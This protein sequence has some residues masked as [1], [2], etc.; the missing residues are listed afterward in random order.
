MIQADIFNDL[1]APELADDL[2]RLNPQWA[3]RPGPE[4][5]AF[6]RHLFPRIY[7]SL[8]AGLTPATVLR[9]LQVAAPAAEPEQSARSTRPARHGRR[10]ARARGW[11]TRDLNRQQLYGGGWSGASVPYYRGYGPA[12]YSN[13]GD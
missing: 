2:R 3:A 11:S 6:H 8:Q 5:P 9:G 12:P 1:L 7:R 13:S 4:I 10:V